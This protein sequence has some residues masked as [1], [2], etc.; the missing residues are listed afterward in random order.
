MGL[1]ILWTGPRPYPQEQGK[2]QQTP[3]VIQRH[4]YDAAAHAPHIHE[5]HVCMSV[6]ER[7]QAKMPIHFL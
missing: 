3:M 7:A 5:L 4:W 6:C 1:I 2:G